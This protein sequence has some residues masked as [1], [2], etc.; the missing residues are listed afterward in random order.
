M[1]YRR[2][3][4]GTRKTA[5]CG[6]LTALSTALLYLSAFLPSGQLAVTAAAG[7]FPVAAVIAFG[8]GAGLLC[9]AGSSLLGLLLSPEK[10]LC[11]L[12]LLFLGLYPVVKSVLEGLKSRIVEWVCKFAYFNVVL[13]LFLLVLSSVFLPTLPGFL[14]QTGILFAVCNVVF[15]VYD[16]G[17][18]RLIGIYSGRLAHGLGRM[19]K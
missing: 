16:M 14:Q 6:I 5:L 13:A 1:S 11:L 19:G 4:S 10:G 15:F 8:R 17:L 2:F 12:Y 3:S 18:S 9:W 7:L